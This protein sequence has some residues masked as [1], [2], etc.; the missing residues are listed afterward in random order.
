VT[1]QIS[2]RPAALSLRLAAFYFAQFVLV[3]I[4]LPYWP[5][6][7]QSRGM[8]PV[9]IAIIL[10]TGRWASVFTT[11]V[12]ATLADRRGESK[13]LLIVLTSAVL[14]A[15]TGNHFAHGFWPLFA[16]AICTA[17]SLSP[18]MPV[19]ESLTMGHAVRGQVDYGR[20]R[21]WG[22]ISFM[23][24]TFA[25]GALLERWR[26][27]VILWAVIVSAA[28]TIIVAACLPDTRS[29]LVARRRGAFGHLARSPVLLLFIAT[30]AFLASSHA[31][32]YAFGTIYWRQAGLGS[33]FIGVLWAEGVVA[34]ILLFA[35]GGAFMR[36]IR[37]ADALLLAAAGGILRWIVL[38][39][40]TEPAA[41]IAVQWLHAL[42]FGAA[43]LGGMAFIV[44]AAPAGFSATV[45]SLYATFGMG[46]ASALAILLVGP[47]YA[48][49]GGP[50]AYHA[51][52]ALSLA[53][54]V[55]ALVLRRVWDG[56]RIELPS[57]ETPTSAS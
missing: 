50:G 46:A 37:P 56:R 35:F 12:V 20:V 40:T 52:V 2:V 19:V 30:V 7:L 39:A 24:A 33:G 27:D 47:L 31:A 3:G 15:Y 22:S 23:L 4:A 21:L 26:A 18:V 17:V 9:E 42:T 48:R 53:G 34:E 1:D 32:L 14:A 28:A 57:E 10:S 6:W 38:A 5:V 8:G 45:Q 54:G 43:H 55:A 41:L 36:R 16:I 44:Q 13:I 11:P 49:Y 25:G 51:M 29:E